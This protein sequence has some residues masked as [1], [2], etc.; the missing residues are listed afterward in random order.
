[1]PKK[2]INN[3]MPDYTGW[4][5][6]ELATERRR[7][8]IQVNKQMQRFNKALPDAQS[9]YSQYAKPYLR[10][11]NRKTFSTAKT[12][13]KR[14]TKQAQ[15]RAEKAELAAMNRII[16][17]KTHTITGY[18]QVKQAAVKGIARAAGIK[19]RSKAY[20]NFI[21]SGI[22]DKLLKSNEWKWLKR[23]SI[24]SPLLLEISRRVAQGNATPD[25]VL[26]RLSDLQTEFGA[27]EA[28]EDMAWEDII[29]FIFDDFIEF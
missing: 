6:E 29:D 22:A 14:K 24:G 8:A 18:K 19:P 20:K 1:M 3:Q 28:F 23:T 13:M 9:A 10:Q 11:F 26:S 15:I 25:E 7:L 5:L 2:N 12:P 21:E 17:S 4:S 16:Q 27:N